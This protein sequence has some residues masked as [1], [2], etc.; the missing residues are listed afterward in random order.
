LD[1]SLL[2]GEVRLCR[3][4]VFH[5]FSTLRTSMPGAI[6]SSALVRSVQKEVHEEASR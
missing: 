3:M 6:S 2:P 1:F 5:D 4:I